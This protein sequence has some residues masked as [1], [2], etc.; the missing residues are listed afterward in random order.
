MI[1]DNSF[2]ILFM[3]VRDWVQSARD[4]KLSGDALLAAMRSLHPQLDSPDFFQTRMDD[5]WEKSGAYSKSMFLLYG[6]AIENACKAYLIHTGKIRVVGGEA[7]GLRTDHDILELVKQAGYVPTDDEMPYLRAIT[8]HTQ[9]GGKYPIAK[10]VKVENSNLQN[11]VYS[12]APYETGNITHKIILAVLKEPELI[13][14][15]EQ[16]MWAFAVPLD[17]AIAEWEAE[18]NQD[19]PPT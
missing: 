14:R 5:F 12:I 2:E 9:Y 11:R 1:D 3:L 17:Q 18:N 10:S 8:W 4:L 15:F 6:L 16:G 19:Q 7:K 13:A